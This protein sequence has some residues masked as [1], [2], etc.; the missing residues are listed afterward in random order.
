MLSGTGGQES[1]VHSSHTQKRSAA[2]FCHSPYSLWQLKMDK[3]IYW[4][5]SVVK[6]KKKFNA[7]SSH[8][9]EC[10]TNMKIAIVKISLQAITVGLLITE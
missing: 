3:R 6:K 4:N 2:A 1:R 9:W 8:L 7:L 5:Y 10:N